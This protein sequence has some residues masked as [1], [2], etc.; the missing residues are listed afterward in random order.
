MWCQICGYQTHEGCCEG[1]IGHTPDEQCVTVELLD[2]Q[3][4]VR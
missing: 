4:D 3:C 2:D 1:C